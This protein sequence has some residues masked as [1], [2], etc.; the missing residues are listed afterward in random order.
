VQKLL[1]LSPAIGNDLDYFKSIPMKMREEINQGVYIITSDDNIDTQFLKENG[2]DIS[3]TNC[4]D[5]N[6]L[7]QVSIPTKS[8][9]PSLSLVKKAARENLRYVVGFLEEAQ[10]TEKHQIYVAGLGG[11][12]CHHTC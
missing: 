7:K 9:N 12:C 1:S 3:I 6:P 11:M 10:E 8:W 2:T 4:W 5:L